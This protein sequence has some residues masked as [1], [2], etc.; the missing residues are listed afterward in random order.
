MFRIGIQ[1]LLPDDYLKNREW[2]RTLSLIS[3]LGI[4]HLELNMTDPLAVDPVELTLF[5]QSKSLEITKLATGYTAKLEKLNLSSPDVKIRERT[6]KRCSDFIS[7][8]HKLKCNVIFGS[9]KGLVDLPK[10]ESDN[11]LFDS[12]KSLEEEI[13]SQQIRVFLEAINRNETTSVNT[14]DEGFELIKSLSVKGFTVL[15]DTYHMNIEE[16]DI[17]ETLKKN[18]SSIDTIH[19]SD[20]NRFYPGLGNFNFDEFIKL[21]KSIDFIGTL[22]IEGNIKGSFEDDIR[23]SMSYFQGI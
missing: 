1:L 19:I 23:K 4:D 16:S 2:I 8:A 6:L 3:M 17:S 22:T 18:I 14:V 9:I 20:N 11:N 12:L 13:L 15:P 21:L 5:M 7:L 10:S